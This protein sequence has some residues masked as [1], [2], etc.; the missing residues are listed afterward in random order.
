LTFFYSFLLLFRSASVVTK[1]KCIRNEK[2]YKQ[3]RIARIVRQTKSDQSKRTVFLR[4]FP[5]WVSRGSDFS[6]S[7]KI[8]IDASKWSDEKKQV[9]GNSIESQRINFQLNELEAQVYQLFSDYLKINPQ[10]NPKEFKNHIEYKLFNKGAGVEAKIWVND[11]FD[12]YLE[13]HGSTL[14]DSRKKRYKFVKRKVN[15][16]NALKFGT[17]KV[18]L[19]VLNREWYIKF[20]E[21]MHSEFEYCTDTLTGYLKVLRSAV[22]DLHKNGHISINPFLNCE[23]EYGEEKQR[24]LNRNELAKI[25]N[26]QST[27]ERLQIVADCFVFASQ[28]GLSHS[29]MR[30]LKRTMIKYEGNQL[31]INKGRDKTGVE[32]IIPIN[33]VALKIIIKYGNDPRVVNSDKALPV[34]H[35]NDYNTILKRIADQCGIVNNELSSH[36]ARH[37][38]ATTVWLGNGGSIETLRVI[39]GHKNIRTTMKY[40]KINAQRVTEEAIRVFAQP[41]E[42]GGLNPDKYMFN[43][44]T[45]EQ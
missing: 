36:V 45:N 29:D 33:D 18:E 6:L 3:I 7:T 10:P 20:K 37:T 44:L 24:H 5:L 1:I 30:T 39:L 25:V 12:L 21:F 9:K 14:G 35:L 15:K 31:V 43:N 16:F 11:I 17:E 4:I 27:D 8:C 26:Y 19:D 28:T 22:L 40:G 32:C 2:M 23:L 42:D 34:I 41:L 38:F 13:L